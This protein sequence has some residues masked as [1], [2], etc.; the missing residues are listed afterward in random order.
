MLTKKGYV[1]T[2][3]KHCLQKTKYKPLQNNSLKPIDKPTR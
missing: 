2:M 1:W 3:L